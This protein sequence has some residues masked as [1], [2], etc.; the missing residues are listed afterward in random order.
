MENEN[1]INFLDKILRE[2]NKLNYLVGFANLTETKG[3]FGYKPELP[4][5]ISIALPL[6]IDIVKN[7]VDGPTK[8]YYD[9]Y[10]EFQNILDWVCE[11]LKNNLVKKG[12]T[13]IAQTSQY[14]TDKC[15]IMGTFKTLLPQKTI[16]VKG[17]IGWIGKN[18]LLVTEEYGSAVRLTSVLT[19][20]PV[21]CSDKFDKPKCGNCEVCKKNCPGKAIKGE[22]WHEGIE[23]DELIDPIKCRESARKISKEKIGVVVSLCG[24][25]FCVC[26]YTQRYLKRSEK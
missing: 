16:A 19:N 13:A 10:Y 4:F 26:P 23:R 25:C 1:I 20:A 9:C 21:E 12:Y 8:E 18:D 5:G 22:I 7:I 15:T 24:K 14:V 2:K 17:G 6:P 11:E 3:S